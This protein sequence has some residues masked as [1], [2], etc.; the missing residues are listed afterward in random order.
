MY[1][2]KPIA[3]DEN[4]HCW[5]LIVQRNLIMPMSL[6]NIENLESL[7]PEDSMIYN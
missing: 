4:G 5:I 2:S 7:K 1:K 3:L 6:N